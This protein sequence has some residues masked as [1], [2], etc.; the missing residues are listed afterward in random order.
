LNG[1]LDWG[2]INACLA[3]GTAAGSVLAAAWTTRR[4][5]IVISLCTAGMSLGGWAAGAGLPLPV[6]LGATAIA[7]A[8][9]GPAGVT[10]QTLIQQHIP[11]HELGRVAANIELAESIPIPIAYAIAGT[12]ADRLGTQTS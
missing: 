2:L 4:P 12:T 9:Y 6:I 1:A 7:G 11:H 5:G 3:G 8:A 10:R